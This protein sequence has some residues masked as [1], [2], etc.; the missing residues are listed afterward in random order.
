MDSLGGRMSNISMLIA[1]AIWCASRLIPLEYSE[2]KI[3]T[4]VCRIAE[5]ISASNILAWLVVNT[6]LG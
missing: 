1:F 6:G 3:I 4:A 5:V 2:D